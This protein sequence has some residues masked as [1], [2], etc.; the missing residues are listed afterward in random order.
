MWQRRAGLAWPG[1][2]RRQQSLTGRPGKPRPGGPTSPLGPIEGPRCWA[3]M[4]EL[5]DKQDSPCGRKKR[6][7]KGSQ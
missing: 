4:A 3:A 1:L 6:D 7:Q 5:Q 2:A